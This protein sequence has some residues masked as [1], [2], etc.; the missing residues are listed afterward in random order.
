MEAVGAAAVLGPL[1]AAVDGLLGTDLTYLAGAEV[2]ELLAGLE[3]QR[4][5]LAALDH[6]VLAQVEERRLAGEYAAA[7]PVDLL[8]TRLRVAPGEA[9][10]RLAQARD[11]GPRRELTGAPLAPVLPGC[12]A[13][14]AAGDI[15]PGHVTVIA[16]CLDALPAHVAVHAAS[17]AEAFLVDAARHEHPKALERTAALLLMRLDPDGQRPR[18][19]DVDR[20]RDFSLLKRGDGCSLPRGL[21][22]AEATAAVEA[23]LDSLAAPVPG[24]DGEPDPRTPGQRRHD[25]LAEAMRRLLRGGLPAAG[26]VPVTI[27]A[28]VTLTEWEARHDTTRTGTARTGHGDIWTMRTTRSAAAGGRCSG[29]DSSAAGGGSCGG[30][31]DI[32]PVVVND[33]GGVLCL[34]RTRRLANRAQRLALAARDSGCC[35][36]D[37]TRPAAWTEVHH[38]IAWADGGPTDIS[39]LCLLC[40]YH[41]RHFEQAGWT[42][43]ITPDGLPTWTPPPWLD[44]TRQT[45]RNTAHHPPD[46]TFPDTEPAT[47]AAAQPSSEPP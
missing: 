16:R 10:A 5:R 6:A 8:V 17:V 34:G 47:A 28:T 45:R 11:C 44:P 4:R 14:V 25:G 7:N 43:H 37:C 19:N 20:A 21:L 13:A 22:T 32:V 27:L 3:V 23:V 40:A 35:F 1:R 38:V 30:D 33:A 24:V 26:G 46:I 15:S 42:V 39:N 9:K 2:V 18:E 31:A 29:G 41:H 36:P 12:A